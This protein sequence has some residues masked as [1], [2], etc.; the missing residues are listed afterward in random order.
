MRHVVFCGDKALYYHDDGEFGRI[1]IILS[2]FSVLFIVLIYEM[3]EI[4]RGIATI[5]DQTLVICKFQLSLQVITITYNS[6][7]LRWPVHLRSGALW[8]FIW[9][10]QDQEG[11]FC[12]PGCDPSWWGL[13]H[14]SHNQENQGLLAIGVERW[15]V[16]TITLHDLFV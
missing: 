8:T 12:W 16:H 2:Q 3:P 13:P 7:N 10:P 9:V 5:D 4:V 15:V 6:S 1:N 11:G 14:P